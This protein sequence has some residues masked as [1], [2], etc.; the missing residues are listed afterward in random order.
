M[1]D[2]LV[3]KELVWTLVIPTICLIGIVTNLI[4][5]YIFAERKKMGLRNRMHQYFQI[6]SITELFYLLICLVFYL[7]KSKVLSVF[8]FTYFFVIYEKY[9]FVY[10]TSVLACFLLFLRLYISIRRLLITLNAGIYLQT[11]RLRKMLV[12]FLASSFFMNLPMITHVVIENNKHA[13]MS[14]LGNMTLVSNIYQ[15]NFKRFMG[16]IGLRV[17]SFSL[18]SFRGFVAPFVLLLVN[19]AIVNYMRKAFNKHRTQQGE[20]I[21]KTLTL[22]PEIRRTHQTNNFRK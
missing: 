4:N 9:F 15:I 7:L 21:F 1:I 11:I 12:F 10:M 17:I 6:D 22:D 5:F 19:L 8:H 3:V 14:G 18:F 16:N 2:I 20:I 13:N